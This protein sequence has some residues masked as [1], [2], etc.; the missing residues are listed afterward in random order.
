MGVA[1][2]RKQYLATLAAGP[3]PESGLFLISRQNGVSAVLTAKP[4]GGGKVDAALFCVDEWQEG[5]FQCLGRRYESA[6]SFQQE[7]RD[8]GAAFRVSTPQECRLCV[9]W[10]HVI[11]LRARVPVPQAFGEWKFLLSPMED[12]AAVET[13]YGCPECGSHLPEAMQTTIRES[14][15]KKLA[16]YFVCKECIRMKRHKSV[17]EAGFPHR[18]RM[19]AFMEADVFS[20]NPCEDSGR[21]MM[22]TPGEA[23]SG[24]IAL[25]FQQD[26]DAPK[27]AAFA[28]ETWIIRAAR[29]NVAIKDE[30][31]LQA[32]ENLP[33]FRRSGA[34]LSE[35]A[36]REVDW[37]RRAAQDGLAAFASACG[38]K[39]SLD[40]QEQAA[41][42]G[43]QKVI[44]SVRRHQSS[45]R[46][47]KYID[48]VSPYIK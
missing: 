29:P 31:I 28:L 37:I 45:S 33:D 10:G 42:H 40:E 25:N 9:G 35:T 11:R 12:L 13:L 7:F 24:A 1:K 20:L 6:D 43:L 17:E 18:R 15:A 16:C 8:N 47:R 46:P 21:L 41:T 39:L 3:M 44:N 2:R 27:T 48:F 34:P 23:Q 22:A 38:G 19:E 14:V 26:G 32:L 5:L 30:H 36:S 4:A